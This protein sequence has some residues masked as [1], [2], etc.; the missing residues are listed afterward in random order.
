VRR[1]PLEGRRF[2]LAFSMRLL[3]RVRSHEERVEALKGLAHRPFLGC[4]AF[5][6][7]QE[8][9]FPEYDD[10]AFAESRKHGTLPAGKG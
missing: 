2:E 1:L 5:A 9:A 10:H 3:H 7:L 6:P 4:H 8:H